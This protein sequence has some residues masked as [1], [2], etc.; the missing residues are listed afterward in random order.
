MNETLLA[1]LIAYLGDDYDESMSAQAN[2]CVNRAVSSFKAYMNYPAAFFVADEDTGVMP[3]E[4][5]MQNNYYCLFDLVL[6]FW[7]LYGMEYQT[8]H[9]EAGATLVFNTEATI[10]ATHGVIPYATVM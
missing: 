9:R 7:N 1:E 6:Y 5:D 2:L 10:Y 8:E 3:Y 4:T